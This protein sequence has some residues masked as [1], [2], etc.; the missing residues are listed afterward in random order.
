MADDLLKL[1]LLAF[2][3]QAGVGQGLGEVLVEAFTDRQQALVGGV[4]SFHVIAV[5]KVQQPLFFTKG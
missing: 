4:G 2:E 1:C 5:G 3:L